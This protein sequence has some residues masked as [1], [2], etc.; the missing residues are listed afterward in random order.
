MSAKNKIKKKP[1]ARELGSAIIEI[2]DKV[3]YNTS[4]LRQ[5]DEILGLYMKMKGDLDNF[6]EFLK[7]E[8]EKRNESKGNGDIDKQD[9]PKD[10]KNEG[11][12]TEG[13]REEAK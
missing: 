7:E 11:S 6:N 4:L 8:M 5:F 10:S 3:N 2:N 1:T 13:V 12:G 9:I